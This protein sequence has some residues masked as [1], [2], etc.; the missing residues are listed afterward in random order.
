MLKYSF[1][2]KA[3]WFTIGKFGAPWTVENARAEA[4][5]LTGRIAEGVDPMAEKHS[6]KIERKQAFTIGELCDRYMEAAE[7]GLILTRLNRP[8][9][10]STLEID[11]GRIK[12]HIKPLI[13][14]LPVKD[15]DQPTVRRMISDSGIKDAASPRAMCIVPMLRLL[16][17]LKRC[18]TAWRT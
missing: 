10:A 16:Q 11:T 2:G 12:R 7:A 5:R 18:R 17:R 14:G 6:A 1:D 13:G 9:K 4:R 3:R 15:V 8:K